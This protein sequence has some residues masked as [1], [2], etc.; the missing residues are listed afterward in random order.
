MRGPW[1]NWWLGGGTTRMI[2][3]G[4]VLK[5]AVGSGAGAQ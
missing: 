4:A 2:R 1:W 5:T 3:V